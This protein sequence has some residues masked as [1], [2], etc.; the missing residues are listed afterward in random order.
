MCASVAAVVVLLCGMVRAQPSL[1]PDVIVGDIIA[2]PKRWGIQGGFHAYT[3]GTISCNIGDADAVWIA[4]TPDH[5]VI[6]QN[7]YRLFT[8]NG[9]KRLEQIGQ[10]WL[11]HT[12]IAD[13][14]SLCG[15]CNGM[16]GGQLGAG[17]SDPYSAT[18][19]GQQIR[20]GPRSDV[21]AYTGQFPYPYTI[22]W[23]LQGDTLY[24]RLQ[25]NALD[26]ANGATLIVE[27]HY[28]SPDDAAWGNQMNNAS[29]RQFIT[30]QLMSDGY[31]MTAV[32]ATRR[33]QPAIYA[34]A[35]LDP[36]V[37]VRVVNVP[38]DGRLYVAYKVTPIGKNLW[39]YEYAVQ[40]LNSHRCAGSFSVP[41][42]TKTN[43]SDIGFR[44]VNCHSGE[45]YS[46][47]D[48]A[49][50]TG[51]QLTW[52]TQTFAQN[53][54]ANPIRWG[55]MY[56]FRFDAD[57]PPA[58][59]QVSLGLFRPGAPG[60]PD[61]LMVDALVP[62]APTPPPPDCGGD[63][64]G[65]SVVNGADL[66]VLLSQFG[67]TVSPGAGADFNNDGQVDGA[68]LSVLLSRFGQSC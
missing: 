41:V 43:L 37:T 52:S 50:A 56:N 62:D 55:T 14:Q 21:N 8:V 64:N 63:A 16:G 17:C 34:W 60:D 12:F 22:G 39:H 35:E 29:Y 27:G 33:M 31:P 40:N 9:T 47:V 30:G 66:S 49:A 6:A 28:V 44:D 13:T 4:Q 7:L 26:L 19:N 23:N 5:P 20:L 10:S 65:D 54:L 18:V 24:K 61:T 57:R 59:G 1:G 48:W 38:G 51:A 42:G 45:P 15:T 67:Q 53:P 36:G 25:V 2:T 3:F 68:D 58:A 11:K 46:N 32:A